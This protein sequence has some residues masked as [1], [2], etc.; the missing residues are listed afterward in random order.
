MEGFDPFI[1]RCATQR[2]SIF[3]CIRPLLSLLPYA[4]SEDESDVEG[5]D[6]TDGEDAESDEDPLATQMEDDDPL[7][8]QVDVGDESVG[9]APNVA[10]SLSNATRRPPLRLRWSER[11]RDQGGYVPGTNKDSDGLTNA[12]VLGLDA[13]ENRLRRNR[14]VHTRLT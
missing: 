9:S 7:A 12:D 4:E 8:T 13:T 5:C 2:M 6:G 1:R 14:T 3:I 11:L 10:S